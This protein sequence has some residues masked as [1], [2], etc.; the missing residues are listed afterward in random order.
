MIALGA[1]GALSSYAPSTAQSAGPYSTTVNVGPARVEV[2]VDPARVGPNETHVYLFDR[3]TGAPFESAEELRLT[4]EMP[5]K[6]S[7]R[8]RS[9]RTSPAPATTSSTPPVLG[10][11]GD[12][13]M[14][15]TVRVSD[16]DEYTQRFT[17]P[18]DG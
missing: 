8:S 2:T 5:S 3:K 10:V 15:M 4:A 12:W 11:A 1:T 17:V 18:I 9:S 6:G 14:E 13:T 16:F 7:P